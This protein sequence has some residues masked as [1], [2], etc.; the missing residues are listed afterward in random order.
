MKKIIILF[1]SALV[2][3][4]TGVK[5][6]TPEAGVSKELAQQRVANISKVAYSLTFNIPADEK[7]DVSGTATITFTENAK[8]D[9][10]LD[11]Q[12]RLTGNCMVNGRKRGVQ[13]INEH[14]IIP[15][16]F[17]KVGENIV[18]LSF[19]S[20][21]KGLNRNGDYMY[22]LFVPDKA[23]SCF[24]CFDQPDLRA[25]FTAQLTVPE[26]WKSIVN[27]GLSPIPTYLFSFVA[28]KF[29]E[30][31][32]QREGYTLRALYRETDLEK[33]AQFD[34]IFDEVGQSIKWMEGYTGLKY[35]FKE[36]GM[37][38]LPGYQ[39]GGMEHPGAVQ[40]SE[41][42]LFLSKKPSQ[43][44][45]L[46]RAELIAHETAHQWFGNMVSLKWFEDIWAKELIANFMASKITRR[47]YSKIDH[48][49][50][51]LRTYHARALAI[52]RTEGTH[53]IAQ[54]LDNL[55]HAGMLYDAIVYDKAPVMMRILEQI[56]TPEVLQTGLQK[57]LNTYY[58][59][60]ASWD[61]LI[62]MLDQEAPSAGVKEFCNVWLKEKGMPLIHT[63]YKDGKLVVR[64]TDPYGRG[65]C[66]RQKF[67]V[68]LIY[69]M[70]RSRT[71]T[72][73]MRDTTFTMATKRPSSI[74]PNY[75][76]R[77]Y[78]RFTLDEEYT[79]KLP[80]RLITTRNDMQRYALLLTLYDNYLMGRIPASYF[81]EIY[82]C[83]IK[84]KNPL[85]MQLAV[86]HMMKIAFDQEVTSRRTLEQCIMDIIP[87]NRNPECRQT[88][89]RIMSQYATSPDVLQQIENIWTKH[90]DP[91]F[92]EHDYMNMAYRLAIMNPSRWQQ[93][94]TTERQKLKNDDL[95]KEFDYVSRACN[96]DVAAQKELFN[97]LLKPE[98]RVQEPWALHTLLL[99]SS[100][101]REPQSISYI[102]PGLAALP[103][104][105]QTSD[106]FFPAGWAAA[107]ISQ[108]KGFDAK[109][110]VE[111]FLSSNTQCPQNLKNKVL[112][113][114]WVLMK[115][116]FYVEAYKAKPIVAPKPAKRRA[117]PAKKAP[118]K[119]K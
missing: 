45:L 115:Q 11:F 78:G 89:V 25:H 100:D 5:A 23:R 57:Y 105:Q 76:G 4:V 113:A 118:A 71:V 107:L 31:T 13:L 114:A 93:I 41:R 101:V 119:K 51:F 42:R 102:A 96:P 68:R 81:G 73:D 98:N 40:F 82:R 88:I 19:V 110:E 54:P 37:I 112:E 49:L 38:I 14:I 32:A 12:G 99:L 53:P 6:Q 1:L 67:D 106:V 33:V 72:V 65:L 18:E 22:T 66:W 30:V 91:Q 59:G 61:D 35:P 34:K 10:I 74:I 15:K 7:Q 44:E 116:E 47:Q 28:G 64:Q 26:G 39:M 52:D 108:H 2:L 84:E 20:L 80:L 90:N 69:D 36:Y 60:S 29:N 103:Q 48:D 17:V 9:V 75:D 70:D 56:M 16:K 55:N 104:I 94:I 46:N 62:N 97:S 86:T 58:F 27:D 111:K 87:E 50:N 83:M 63:T 92:N 117:A 8:E 109:A 95:L 79:R 3:T 85:I 77:G 24:P 21:D 43:E